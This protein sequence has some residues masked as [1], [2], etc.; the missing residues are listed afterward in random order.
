[1][2]PFIY[3]YVVCSKTPI[4]GLSKALISTDPDMYDFKVLVDQ[5]NC[6]K[7]P[8]NDRNKRAINMPIRVGFRKKGTYQGIKPI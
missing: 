6:E 5:R 8:F 7:G 4:H 2:S 1:M 3:E